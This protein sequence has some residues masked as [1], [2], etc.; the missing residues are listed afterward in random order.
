[1]EATVV[2]V[3]VLDNKDM[4]AYLPKDKDIRWCAGNGTGG[5]LGRPH[6]FLALTGIFGIPERSDQSF[7]R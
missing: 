3:A 4:V 1:M 7:V 5:S 2:G 6:P